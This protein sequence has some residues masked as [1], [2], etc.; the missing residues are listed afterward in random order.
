MTRRERMLAT[1][2]H[3]QPERVPKHIRFSPAMLEVFRQKTGSSD[4]E[5]YYDLELT[6]TIPAPPAETEP[7]DL[8]EK[9]AAYHSSL[10]ETAWLD[11]FGIGHI[12]GS[13]YHFARLAHPLAHAAGAS[14]L[15]RYPWP[16]FASDPEAML[17]PPQSETAGGAWPTYGKLEAGQTVRSLVARLK[18]G[19]RFVVGAGGSIFE[20]SWQLRGMD[21]L[22]EDFQ[23]RPAFA[24]CL[25]DHVLEAWK[26]GVGTLARAGADMLRITDDVG[27][28]NR[29][30]MAPEVWRKWLKPRLAELIQTAR[31]AKPDIFI[32]YHSDGDITPIIDELIEVGVDLLDPVQPECM[33]PAFV[34][35]RWGDRI[36]LFGTIGTQTTFPF[37]SPEEVRRVVKERIATC[38]GNGGL[39]LAP[40]HILEPDVPWANVEAFIEAADEHRG[41]R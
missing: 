27:M 34:K 9:F 35:K 29:M 18:Q 14:D 21:L 26:A 15:E 38:G 13:L 11:E 41:L 25:L 16:R 31:L 36:S 3:R 17:K 2:E 8:R 6:Y 40:T 20:I 4:P 1:L 28:Q 32:Q 19:D 22:F 24:E 33:D 23:E 37:G 39:V 5:G 7:E 30:L 10:P 12:P